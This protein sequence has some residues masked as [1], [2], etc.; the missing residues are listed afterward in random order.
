MKR[1][2]SVSM[3]LLK[4]RLFRKYHKKSRLRFDSFTMRSDWR[5]FLEWYPIVLSSAFSSRCLGQDVEYDYVMDHVQ[6]LS[7]TRI[8]FIRNQ[9]V[10]KRRRHVGSS[11]MSETMNGCVPNVPMAVLTARR[12]CHRPTDKLM[13]AQQSVVTSNDNKHDKRVCKSRGT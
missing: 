7:R 5:A 8:Q 9:N 10:M 1:I 6:P 3:L 4:D 12:Q 11:M 2:Q 13:P